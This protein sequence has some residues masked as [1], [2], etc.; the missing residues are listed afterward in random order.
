MFDIDKKPHYIWNDHWHNEYESIWGLWEKFRYVNFSDIAQNN[1]ISITRYCDEEKFE[2]YL[3]C[4]L[5]KKRNPFCT[6]YEY[7]KKNQGNLIFKLLS[8]TY[9]AR[10]LFHDNLRYCPECMKH[11]YHSYFHQVKFTDKCFIHG[12]DLV[13]LCSCNYKYRIEYKNKYNNPFECTKCGNRIE[14]LPDKLDACAINWAIPGVHIELN[15]R[16]NDIKRLS[17]IDFFPDEACLKDELS[18]NQKLFL[19]HIILNQDVGEEYE[20]IFKIDH[21]SEN[22][23][24][25]KGFGMAIRFH[26]EIK[27]KYSNED[28]KKQYR[29]VKRFSSC[30]NPDEIEPEIIAMFYLVA[31]LLYLKSV[32]DIYSDYVGVLNHE[33]DSKLNYYNYVL[34]NWVND[35]VNNFNRISYDNSQRQKI[36][37]NVIYEIIVQFR[38]YEFLEFFKEK[39][40][41][42]STVY[43]DRN[44]PVHRANYPLFLVVEYNNGDIEIY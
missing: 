32:E 42:G 35:Y 33:E 16:I 11:G 44:I 5:G 39:K 23:D 12:C 14:D 7:T 43:A 9:N 27:N 38:Y 34:T 10:C 13:D 4:F 6:L 8:E 2:P 3:L 41:Y 22:I 18:D 31:E 37:C 40:K 17:I 30:D 15:N 36:I 28:L 20:P 25:S 21:I 24:Y 19:R 1:L 29:Y 26:H